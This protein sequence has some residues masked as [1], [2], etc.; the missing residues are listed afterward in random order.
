MARRILHIFDRFEGKYIAVPEAGCWIWEGSVSSGSMPYGLLWR[1]GGRGAGFDYAH[2][3]SYRKHIGPIPDGLFVC[4]RC[5]TPLCVNPDHLFLGTSQDN[6]S[7]RDKK[8]RQKTAK[9]STHK[10]AKITEQQALEIYHSDLSCAKLGKL[11]GIDG[12]L[13][14]RIKHKKS[15]AHIHKT[16][17]ETKN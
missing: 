4:H 8:G 12:A 5:D 9:G 11:Y 10:L 1:D 16:Q 14:H 6:T 15:W 17:A 3:V 7:D 2:R 13:V